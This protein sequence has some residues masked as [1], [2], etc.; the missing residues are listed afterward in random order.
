MRPLKTIMILSVLLLATS[1]KAQNLS[2]SWIGILNAGPSKLHLVFNI[3]KDADGRETC[4][5][6]SPDQAAKNIPATVVYISPDS[7]K[8]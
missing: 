3:E 8:G 6:D 7:L 2:G 4:L 1:V 5:M